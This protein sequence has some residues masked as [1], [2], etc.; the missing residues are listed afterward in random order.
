MTD[1][2][3]MRVSRVNLILDMLPDEQT[4]SRETLG[5]AFR[6]YGNKRDTCFRRVTEADMSDESFV[7]KLIK[8][9][10]GR[11]F[12]ENLFAN[13]SMYANIA[14]FWSPDSKIS[15]DEVL[16]FFE[17][18]KR[19]NENYDVDWR[20]YLFACVSMDSNDAKRKMRQFVKF[21][22]SGIAVDVICESSLM[23]NIRQIDAAAI[24]MYTLGRD[25]EQS[26]MADGYGADS[27][28]RFNFMYCQK[29]GIRKL[30]DTESVSETMQLIE[31]KVSV[32]E[33]NKCVDGLVDTI[34]KKAREEW[35]GKRCFDTDAVPI[36][37]RFTGL[38]GAM[39]ANST[40]FRDFM[41]LVRESVSGSLKTWCAEKLPDIIDHMLDMTALEKWYDGVS[42]SSIQTPFGGFVQ[43]SGSLLGKGMT[44]SDFEA[45][46]SS[47]KDDA[48]RQDSLSLENLFEGL[49]PGF[50]LHKKIGDRVNRVMD[51]YGV[52]EWLL[53]VTREKL[54]EY[55]SVIR[56]GRFD[57]KGLVK[58]IEARCERD[59]A[60]DSDLY[61]SIEEY[62]RNVDKGSESENI[63]YQIKSTFKKG[64][65]RVLKFFYCDADSAGAPV[66]DAVS[67]FFRKGPSYIDSALKKEEFPCVCVTIIPCSRNI[68]DA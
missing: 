27:G 8:E 38:R 10:F 21:L 9:D 7:D 59:R 34:A 5:A 13:T 30:S 67:D 12:R 11:G 47:W 56:E 23:K 35:N 36:P 22:D 45:V 64:S 42:D 28:N 31:N 1:I 63:P 61:N 44:V 19:I 37:A 20:Y 25:S 46:T 14:V 48:A 53:S 29:C 65:K 66:D 18:I 6:A 52:K 24:Y 68:F 49:R 54:T 58:R 39:S 57:W 16:N 55:L 62:I 15:Q 26:I 40:E 41:T 51:A 32:D 60:M 3:S 43:D 50:G 17:A 33:W 4:S 2:R